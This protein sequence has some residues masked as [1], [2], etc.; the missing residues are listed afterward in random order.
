MRFDSIARSRDTISFGA[1][2]D[3]NARPGKVGA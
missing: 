1:D 3:P 2:S